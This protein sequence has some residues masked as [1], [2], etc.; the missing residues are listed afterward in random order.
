MGFAVAEVDYVK[1][2]D[3]PLKNWFWE[4]NLTPGF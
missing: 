1:P 4:F 3:R 2:L